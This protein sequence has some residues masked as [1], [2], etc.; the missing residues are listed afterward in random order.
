MFDSNSDG[1]NFGWYGKLPS[2]GDFV[3][4][5]MPYPLQQFWDRWCAAGLESL[6]ERNPVSG[7]ALWGKMPKWAFILPMQPGLPVAQLGVLAPSCDRVGRNY[8]LLITTPILDSNALSI[9]PRA[10]TIAIAWAQVIEEAHRDRASV[11]HFDAQL[12]QAFARE[13]VKEAVVQEGEV[14]LPPG[15]SPS[16]LPWPALS[17]TF[18]L[19][20]SESY[21]WSV[22]PA[23]T[24]FRARTHNGALNTIHFFN[25]H[26]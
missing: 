4:R 16:T 12:A 13:L 24:G 11:D 5:R 18:E 3:S 2:A 10:A 26:T 22:P 20:A 17:E 6:K 25:L 23:G 7:W 15:E 19:K 8:P 1:P 14:T 9:L 21:W